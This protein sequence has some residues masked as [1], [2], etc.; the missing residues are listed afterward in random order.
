MGNT[1]DSERFRSFAIAFLKEAKEDI[2]A[3]E[4]LLEN[5]RYCGIFLSAVR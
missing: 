3:A 2:E 5:K 1:E 4:E